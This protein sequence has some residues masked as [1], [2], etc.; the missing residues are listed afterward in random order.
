MTDGSAPAQLGTRGSRLRRQGEAASGPRGAAGAHGLLRDLEVISRT[1]ALL[2][3][4]QG[5]GRGPRSELRGSL[6]VA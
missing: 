2:G 1:W 6:A 5:G 3:L 4:K